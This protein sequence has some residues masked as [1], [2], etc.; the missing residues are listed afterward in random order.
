MEIF[1]YQNI[2]RNYYGRNFK[3]NIK[4]KTIIIYECPTISDYIFINR[5]I[6]KN[7]SVYII[8]PF[9]AYHHKKGIRFYPPHLSSY[10]E[11]LVQERKIS[12]LKADEINAKEIYQLAADKAVDIIESVFPMPVL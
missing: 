8:E 3:V 12:I 9:G 7:I 4:N 10:I 6:K 2:Y 1:F 5:Y 11:E